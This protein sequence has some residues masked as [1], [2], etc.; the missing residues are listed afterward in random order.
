MFLSAVVLASV[1]SAEFAPLS[2]ALSAV[3][4]DTEGFRTSTFTIIG[5]LEHKYRKAGHCLCPVVAFEF[6]MKVKLNLSEH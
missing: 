1:Y 6:Q 3:F 2:V 5:S 4:T